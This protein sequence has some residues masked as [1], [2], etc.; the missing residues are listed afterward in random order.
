ME[1]LRLFVGLPLPE[2]YQQG[3]AALTRDLKPV[4]PGSCSWTR[5]GNWHLTLKFLGDVPLEA[6]AG[7]QAALAG[8]S[9]EAF[10]LRAGGGGFFP[11]QG[12]PRVA[13]VAAAEGGI[14]C[15]RLAGL[16]ERALAPLGFAPEKRE[17]AA[18]LTVAR[19]KAAR[20]GADWKAALGVML[21]ATWPETV[22][23]RLVLWRSYLGQG[24]GQGQGDGGGVGLPGPRYVPLREFG[25][26][27][28]SA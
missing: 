5:P 3:L 16:V 13:W 24:Q 15:V 26:T 9:W 27:G 6:V 14:E 7:I 10:T 23:D 21:R 1:K 8:I 22:V 11:P 2:S 19:I 25:A 12:R 28:R 4:V 20:A 18:H 17:F